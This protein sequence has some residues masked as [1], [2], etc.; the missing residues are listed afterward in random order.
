MK[1][2]KSREITY[3]AIQASLG[4]VPAAVVKVIYEFHYCLFFE[5]WDG[6]RALR[7]KGSPNMLE[8]TEHGNRL[9]ICP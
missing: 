5:H 8:I 3:L 9:F 4:L 1:T 6:N 7:K 2:Y